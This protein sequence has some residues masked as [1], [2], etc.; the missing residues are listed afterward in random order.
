MSQRPGHNL[1]VPDAF[2]IVEPNVY[3]CSSVTDPLNFPFIRSLQL[4]TFLY[5]SPDSPAASFR[6][7]CQETN[8]ELVSLFESFNLILVEPF[9]FEGMETGGNMETNQ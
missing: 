3:R 8:I 1:I 9:R 5:L 6:K 4:K 2:G 7:F